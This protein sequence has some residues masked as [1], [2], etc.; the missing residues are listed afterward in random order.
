[1]G[2]KFCWLYEQ[3]SNVEELSTCKEVE[4]GHVYDVEESVARVV[5]IQLLYSVTVE[6]IHF[7]PYKKHKAQIEELQGDYSLYI[8]YKNKQAAMCFYSLLYFLT[9]CSMHTT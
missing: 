1:M 6:G 5:R 8:N 7:P 3:W 2:L 9:M 4:D